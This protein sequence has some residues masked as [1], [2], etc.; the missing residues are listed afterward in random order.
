MFFSLNRFVHPVF[1]GKMQTL[2]KI[3]NLDKQHFDL[4]NRKM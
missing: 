4:R 1:G 2:H 3:N